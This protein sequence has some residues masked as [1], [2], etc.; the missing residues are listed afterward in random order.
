MTPEEVSEPKWDRWQK[1]RTFVRAIVGKYGEIYQNLLKQ[2]RVYKSKEMKWKGGPTKFGKNVVNP[3]HAMVTQAIEAHIDVLAPGCFG[4]R[5]G[6]MNSAVFYILEGDGYDVHDG[7]K[8]PWKA[9][10]VCIVENMS[11]HQHFNN[12][13][14]KPARYVIFKAKPTFLFF[15]LMFQR[16]VEYPPKEAKPGFENF[17]PEP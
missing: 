7:V 13:P 12:D 1:D 16:T 5:H 9:G 14:S 2:P 3:Q 10:D 15:N 17:V 8:Y 4:Q 6:H 11:V